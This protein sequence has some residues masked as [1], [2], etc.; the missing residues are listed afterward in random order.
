M[1]YPHLY[2]WDTAWARAPKSKSETDWLSFHQLRNKCTSHIKKAKPDFYLTESTKNLN[3]PK[4]LWQVIKSNSHAMTSDLPSSLI[5]DSAPLSDKT[6][7][8]NCFNDHFVSAG[9]LFESL[10]PEL[11]EADPPSV[12]SPLFPTSTSGG[13]ICPFEFTA[14]TASEV[15]TALKRLDTWKAPILLLSLWHIFL[16]WVFVTR[17]WNKRR[18]QMLDSK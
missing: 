14:V 6:A 4:K 11:T 12:N 16:T 15:Q 9:S 17:R 10:H 3:S 7:I 5:T 1:L 2:L 18:T 13:T 8:L